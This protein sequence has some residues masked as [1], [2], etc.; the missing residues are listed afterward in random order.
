MSDW[1]LRDARGA[2]VGPMGRDV[3][4]DLLRSR[5]GL[6]VFSSQDGVNWTSVRGQPV[7][8]I[9]AEEAPKDRRSR[10]EEQAQLAMFELD[11][12]RELKPH[13]LFGVLD[14]ASLKD[15]RAGFLAI[16]KR[17]HPGRLPRDVA[18]SLL[19]A[20]MAVYQYLSEVMAGVEQTL[21]KHGATHAPAPRWAGPPRPLDPSKVPLWPLDAL[22]LKEQFDSFTC[23][24][25]INRETSV[26]FFVHRLINLPNQG[27]F[28]PCM[29]TLPLGTRLDFTFRFPDAHREVQSRGAVSLE[30][31][32]VDEKHHLRGFGVRF[33]RLSLEDKGFMINEVRRM[34]AASTP[35]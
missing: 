11:R 23:G 35:R 18:P 9:L 19:R 16:A 34:Q 21:S 13:E 20:H 4:L 24:L 2:V 22:H 3:A 6:F 28:F 32:F 31:T 26:I 8:S 17:F 12:F 10:E 15:F 27:C 14:T 29:P 30:S 25:D 33:D 1:Y 7:K 5:P